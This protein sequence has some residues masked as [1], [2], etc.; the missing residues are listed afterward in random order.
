[1][2]W[3]NEE[4]NIRKVIGGLLKKNGF[5]SITYAANGAE[6]YEA[7]EDE[8]IDLIISDVNMPVMDRGCAF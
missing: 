3:I 8:N 5:T 4:K 1:M 6:G 7:V 2:L